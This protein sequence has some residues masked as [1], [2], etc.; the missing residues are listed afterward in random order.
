MERCPNNK[1]RKSC[2]LKRDFCDGCGI[3]LRF[4]TACRQQ[5]TETV[6]RADGFYCRRCGSALGMPAR[7]YALADSSIAVDSS[8]LPSCNHLLL[9]ERSDNFQVGFTGSRLWVLTAGGKLKIVENR[10]GSLDLQDDFHKR[11]LLASIQQEVTL[12]EPC[13]CPVQVRDRLLLIGKDRILSFSSHPHKWLQQKRLV[14]LPEGM[15]AIFG[16]EAYVE[17]DAVL[18]PVELKLEVT[19]LLRVTFDELATGV[20]KGVTTNEL[21]MILVAPLDSAGTYYWAK[22]ARDVGKLLVRKQDTLT[23]CSVP[24][25]LFFVRPEMIGER[26]FAV[27]SEHRLLEISFYRDEPKVRR[28]AQLGRGVSLMRVLSDR[29]VIANHD[30]LVFYDIQTGDMLADAGEVEPTHLFRD[31]QG[32]LLA[33]HRNGQL[34]V[35]NPVKPLERRILGDATS[36]DSSVVD[37]FIVQNSLYSLSEDGEVYRFDFN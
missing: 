30:R 9:G 11:Q 24:D 16:S 4:C 20:V 35:I 31:S 7:V 26:I 19:A 28:L 3:A 37:A 29:I 2:D 8:Q 17:K 21:E 14:P 33:L 6:N 23:L 10:A 18:I 12:L 36:D 25:L 5:G 34:L 15:T 27:S 32:I 1:C 13:I 22:K